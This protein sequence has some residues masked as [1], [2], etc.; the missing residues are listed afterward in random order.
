MIGLSERSDPKKLANQGESELIRRCVAGERAAQ[1]ELY[2]RHRAQVAAN[3]F[4][5]LGERSELEDLV[6]EVFLIAFR[7]LAEFRGDAQ[8]S[9]WLYRIAVNVALGKLRQR[10]RRPPPVALHDRDLE[11][12]GEPPATPESTLRRKESAGRVYAALARLSPKKR[13]VLY[14]HEIEGRE[15]TEIAYLVGANPVTVRTRLY[16]ARREFYKILAESEETE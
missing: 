16:Y 9:T 8:L 4:R 11:E 10:K 6:Q 12:R 14:L 1:V 2:T 15:L 13:L 7:K 3:L 5:V